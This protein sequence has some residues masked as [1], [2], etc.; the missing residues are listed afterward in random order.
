LKLPG[1]MRFKETRRVPLWNGPIECR[2]FS[3]ELMT[4]S[5]RPQAIDVV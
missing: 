4:G 2:M 1:A 3:F 5:P